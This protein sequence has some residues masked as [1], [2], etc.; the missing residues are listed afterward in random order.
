[1][2]KGHRVIKFNH[3]G[4]LKSYIKINTELRKTAK[5]DFEKGIFKLMNNSVFKKTME[6]IRKHRDVNCN[7]RKKKIIWCQNQ[8]TIAQRFSQ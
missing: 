7:N 6:N 8:I 3:W 5:H 4:Y 1:M 2:K